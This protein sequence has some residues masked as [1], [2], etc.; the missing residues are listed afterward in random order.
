MRAFKYGDDDDNEVNGD[1]LLASE[2]KNIFLLT[3]KKK[4]ATDDTIKIINA[5]RIKYIY[6]LSVTMYRNRR[7]RYY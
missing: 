6:T 7:Y 4:V 5:S 1:I 3:K 2:E